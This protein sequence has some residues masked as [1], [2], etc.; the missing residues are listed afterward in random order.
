MER[1][2]K[3]RAVVRRN[4]TRLITECNEELSKDAPDAVILQV[5]LQRLKELREELQAQDEA[6]LNTMLDGD[7][8]EDQC[9]IESQVSG[10]YQRN[11]M[12]V[13]GKINRSLPPLLLPMAQGDQHS[14]H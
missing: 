5:E 2:R 3:G 4:A 9:D 8:T 13:I 11:L 1:Q 6:I 10:E 7:A 12:I 14:H